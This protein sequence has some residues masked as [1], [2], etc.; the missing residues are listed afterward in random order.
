MTD[1]TTRVPT[2]LPQAQRA[3]LDAYRAERGMPPRVKARLVERLEAPERSDARISRGWVLAGIGIAAAVALTWGASALHSSRASV[4][5]SQTSDQAVM[6]G[7]DGPT[8]H[9]TVRPSPGSASEPADRRDPRSPAGS[10]ADAAVPLE[11]PPQPHP[12]ATPTPGASPADA[13]ANVK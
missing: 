1:S 10:A 12:A 3:L 4:A 13:R 7:V 6:H 8:E 11:P 5:G 2:A 9:P